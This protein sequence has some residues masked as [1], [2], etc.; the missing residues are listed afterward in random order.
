MNAQDI[1]DT[2]SQK[3][4]LDQVVTE[5]A[6]GTIF[7][8]LDHEAEGT[9]MA[10]FFDSMPGA[11]D[12]AKRYDVMTP[13]ANSGGSSGGLLGALSSALGSSLGEKTG[14][15]VNGISQL[16]ASGLDA[17]QIREAGTLLI[18]QAEKAAGPDVVNDVIGAVPGLKGHLG[19]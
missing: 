14:A 17:T 3:L 15:L 12:L 16:R 6:V 8:V 13:A 9:R 1:V 10:E 5:K 18:Q 7:S 19:L 4:G 2:V 11:S